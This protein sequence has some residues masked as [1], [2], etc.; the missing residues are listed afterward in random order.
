M[1]FKDWSRNFKEIILPSFFVCKLFTRHL[2]AIIY[3]HLSLNSFH[4]HNTEMT[5]STMSDPINGIMVIT[6]FLSSLKHPLT[7]FL[8]FPNYNSRDFNQLNFILNYLPKSYLL[9]FSPAQNSPHWPNLKPL[10]N[11]VCVSCC[12]IPS[13]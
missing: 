8:P 6:P 11:S 10:L 5:L 7:N 12:P 13:L 3:V 2:H 9:Y 4:S 1:V